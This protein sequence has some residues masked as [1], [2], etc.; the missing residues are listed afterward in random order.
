MSTWL[1][2]HKGEGYEKPPSH[3]LATSMQVRISFLLSLCFFNLSRSAVQNVYITPDGRSCSA[4]N[5]T[6][7]KPCYSLSQLKTLSSLKEPSVALLFLPGTYM[8]QEQLQFVLFH[9]VVMSPLNTEEQVVIECSPSSLPHIVFG[10]TDVVNAS[11]LHF[12]TCELYF[13][14][15][16]Y[17]NDNLTSVLLRNAKI[18]QLGLYYLVKSAVG[19]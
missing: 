16:S 18:V 5:G 14:Y 6:M 4:V 11:S 7:L 1:D 3:C 19:Q 12:T 10:E 9:Q 2:L 17:E 15:D 13:D 8:L